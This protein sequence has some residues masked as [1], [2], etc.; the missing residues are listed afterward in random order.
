MSDTKAV[1]QRFLKR[2]DASVPRSIWLG[3]IVAVPLVVL[4]IPPAG[5]AGTVLCTLV[6][7][8]GIAG[9]A[10]V[11]THAHRR[12]LRREL[13]QLKPQERVEVLVGLEAADDP[14]TRAVVRPVLLELRRRGEVTPATAP[15]GQGAEVSSLEAPA[16]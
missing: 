10:A 1:Q 5:Q 7:V 8:A 6:L 3:S 12:H 14:F 2:I 15:E 9:C 16:P 13:R 11:Y 4:L